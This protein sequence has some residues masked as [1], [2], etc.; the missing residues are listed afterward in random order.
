MNTLENFNNSL[1]EIRLSL[2]KYGKINDAN[3]KLDEVS[4]LLAIKLY[5]IKKDKSNKL[6]K[7][8][9]GYET[10]NDNKFV[11]NLQSL[12]KNIAND[13]M[14]KDSNQNSIFGNNPR[15]EIDNDDDKFAYS[16]I[17]ML[18]VS[19]NDIITNGEEFDLINETFGHFIRSNFR[20]NIEDA[21]YMTPQEVVDLVCGIASKNLP[22]Y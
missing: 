22:N 4:K 14:F 18:D 10:N 20:N 16:I 15:L 17:K 12:F 6:T 2:H 9:S 11:S 21:Q 13:E 1:N 5:D 19:L 7:L 3:A 8:L